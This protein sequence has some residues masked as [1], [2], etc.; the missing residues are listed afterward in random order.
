MLV[1]WAIEFAGLCCLQEEVLCVK[2]GVLACGFARMSLFAAVV[3]VNMT[4]NKACG[5][6]GR[7]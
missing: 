1:L 3:S 2:G 6:C 7:G 5:I 4:A